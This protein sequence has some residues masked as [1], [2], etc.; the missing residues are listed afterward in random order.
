MTRVGLCLYGVALLGCHADAGSSPLSD[1]ASSSDDNGC[2][3]PPNPPVP[4]ATT[5]ACDAQPPDAAGCLGDPY[6]CHNPGQC[7]DAGLSYPVGCTAHIPM[8]SACSGVTNPACCPAV[9]CSCQPTQ[10]WLCP[11]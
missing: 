2:N 4:E 5:Y 8:G 6:E 1:A 9:A 10:A 3:P 7:A 11:L